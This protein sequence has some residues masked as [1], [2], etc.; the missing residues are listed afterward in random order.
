MAV[1]GG[2]HALGSEGIL[3][4]AGEPRA[5]R[6]RGLWRDAWRRLVRNRAAVIGLCLIVLFTAVALLAPYVAPYSYERQD[7]LSIYQAPSSAHLLGTDALGRDMLSRLIYGARVSMSV[8]VITVV[9]VLLIGIPAGLVAGYYGGFID[10]VLM[11]IVDI[12]YA[13]PDLLLIILLSAYLG[14][15]LPR[16]HSGPLL[17][18]KDSYTA[19]GGLIAV[20]IALALRGWLTLA[21]LVR[22]QVLS[23]KERDFID[24]ARALGASNKRIMFAHLL[25]NSLAPVIVASAILVPTFIIAEAGLSFIGVGV[26]PP[27]PSW[28]IMISDGIQA[29]QSHPYVA[30]EPGLAI[31]IILLSFSFLGDGLRDALD[32]FMGG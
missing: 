8:G 12:M 5:V 7:L 18:L 27:T 23:L 21:R 11:R 9:L 17:L 25:P 6:Q 10:N 19:T 13:F 28:G 29:I 16:I 14:A 15:A 1:S 20:V 30:I 3:A 2:T 22:G 26:K 31:A 32:P 24:G 4:D